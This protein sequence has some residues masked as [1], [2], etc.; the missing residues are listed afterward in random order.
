MLFNQA[1]KRFLSAEMEVALFIRNIEH[2]NQYLN[3][4]VFRFSLDE[5]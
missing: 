4:N 1:V 2:Y 5:A 3:W